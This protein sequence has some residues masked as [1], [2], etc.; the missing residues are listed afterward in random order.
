MLAETRQETPRGGDDLISRAFSGNEYV[1]DNVDWDKA[2]RLGHRSQ[3]NDLA[4]VAGR[5]RMSD[6]APGG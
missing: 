5:G 2:R 3:P 4:A 6:A 1:C